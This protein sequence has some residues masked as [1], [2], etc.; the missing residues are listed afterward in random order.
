MIQQRKNKVHEITLVMSAAALTFNLL[1]F[2]YCTGFYH[3]IFSRLYLAFPVNKN[4]PISDKKVP[5]SS[6]D[7]E[8]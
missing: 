8:S 2:D 4:T 3:M 6:Q 5:I 7:K 1:T